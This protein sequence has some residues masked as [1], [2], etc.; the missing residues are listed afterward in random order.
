[1]SPSKLQLCQR[2]LQ[3]RQQQMLMLHR[4]RRMSPSK[5]QLRQRNTYLCPFKNRGRA[6]CRRCTCFSPIFA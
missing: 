5:L 1:M 6:Y 4:Q 2:K 3:L